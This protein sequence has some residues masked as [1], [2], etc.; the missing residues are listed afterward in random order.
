MISSRVTVKQ[1]M[2]FSDDNVTILAINNSCMKFLQYL[3][4]LSF[5]DKQPEKFNNH[6]SKAKSGVSQSFKN[7]HTVFSENHNRKSAFGHSIG[8]NPHFNNGLAPFKVSLLAEKFAK[9]NNHD[10]IKDILLWEHLDNDSDF[11]QK[12]FDNL[13]F[14]EISILIYSRRKLKWPLTKDMFRS[15]ITHN[16]LDLL[17]FFLKIKECRIIL[18]YIEIQKLIVEKYMR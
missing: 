18:D 15:T 1:F 11:L 9:N 6:T 7:S 10:A 13:C 17:L 14:D 16:E 4:E 8:H 12:L 3:W 5:E 2:M